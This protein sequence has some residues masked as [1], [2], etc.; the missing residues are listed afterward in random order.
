MTKLKYVLVFDVSCSI[1]SLSA[2]PE[3]GTI[4]TNPSAASLSS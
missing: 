4:L 2:S 3:A 1:K